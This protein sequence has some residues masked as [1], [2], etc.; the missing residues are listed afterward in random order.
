MEHWTKI[1]L[2]NILIKSLHY[3][4]PLASLSFSDQIILSHCK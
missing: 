4:N 3:G 1:G 2:K